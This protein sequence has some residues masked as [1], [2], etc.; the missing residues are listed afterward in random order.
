MPRNDAINDQRVLMYTPSSEPEVMPA[1]SRSTF[2]FVMTQANSKPRAGDD[3][4][5]RIAKP[6]HSA[7]RSPKTNKPTHEEWV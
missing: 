4:S 7:S 2:K 1:R 5:G 3:V 6:T